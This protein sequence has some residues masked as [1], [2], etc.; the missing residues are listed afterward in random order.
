MYH[1]IK[2]ISMHHVGNYDKA[3]FQLPS[4]YEK[5]SQGYS[6]VTLID[7]TVASVHMGLGTCKLEPGGTLN[8]H[9]HFYEEAFYILEGRVLGS[10]DGRN[11]PFGPG[12]YGLIQAIVSHASRP[13]AALPSRS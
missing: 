6:R 13:T 9:V 1:R 3:S 8:S 11:Y 5:H 7:H 2:E 10:I 12:D 4:T